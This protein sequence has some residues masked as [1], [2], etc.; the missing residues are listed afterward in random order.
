MS[1]TDDLL[2]VDQEFSFD[3]H[4]PPKRFGQQKECGDVFPF[5]SLSL[6]D[7]HPQAATTQIVHQRSSH[8][9]VKN[10][11][12]GRKIPSEESNRQVQKVMPASTD[13]R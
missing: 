8:K 9:S 7:S 1:F 2:P 6:F 5:P 3:E 10:K 11:G 13:C 4:P 12:I